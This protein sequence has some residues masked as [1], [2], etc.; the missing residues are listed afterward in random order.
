M[1]K[2]RNDVYTVLL[3]VTLVSLGL[4]CTLMYLDWNEYGRMS[5]PVEGPA[6]V[7]K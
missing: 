3:F 5:P 2:A 6:H 1:A 7:A 4:G